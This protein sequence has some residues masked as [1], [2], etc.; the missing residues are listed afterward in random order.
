MP[1]DGQQCFQKCRG[2]NFIEVTYSP[3]FGELSLYPSH[4]DMD[5][6]YYFYEKNVNICKL[7]LILQKCIAKLTKLVCKTLSLK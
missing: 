7:C 4:I 2:S 5:C 6:A 3:W 1:G